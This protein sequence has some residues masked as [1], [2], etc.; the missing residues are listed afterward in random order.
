MDNI[1]LVVDTDIVIDFL[2][3]HPSILQKVFLQFKVG[4][5]A[6]T[7][8]EVQAIAVRSARQEQA[9]ADFL[10]LC[11]VLPFDE[12]AA[13]SAAQIWRTL[14]QAE[15][16]ISL[17]DTL[18]AGICFSRS[19]PLLTRNSR[20]YGRVSGLHILEPTDLA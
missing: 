16:L 4:I 11:P 7:L 9:L 15:E 12:Q 6:V 14:Q 5:T 20:R 18:I 19:L 10:T 2:R 3:Q 13:R 1:Q 8:Y 17:P